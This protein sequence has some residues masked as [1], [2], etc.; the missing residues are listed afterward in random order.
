MSVTEQIKRLQKVR[1]QIRTRMVNLGLSEDTALLQNLANDLDG[2]VKR[3]SDDVTVGASAGISNITSI[4]TTQAT[5]GVAV[6]ATA[7]STAS[8]T[9][10]YYP[11]AV[12][13]TPSDSASTTIKPVLASSVTGSASVPASLPSG[14]ISITPST[15]NTRRIYKDSSTSNG[16]ITNVV[17]DEMSSA[18]L[19]TSGSASVVTTPA[20]TAGV[21]GTLTYK[22]SSTKPSGTDGTDFYTL[23]PNIASTTA[24][25]TTASAT[26]TVTAS[27]H[28]AK[29][30]TS[31]KDGLEVVVDVAKNKGTSTYLP[32]STFGDITTTNPTSSANLKSVTPGTDPKYVPVS[33][34][35]RSAGK[36][37]VNAIPSTTVTLKAD[38]WTAATTSLELGGYTQLVTATGVTTSSHV[39]VYPNDT[40]AAKT[41]GVYAYSQA[42]NSLTFRAFDKP[43]ADMKYKV[44]YFS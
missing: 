2:V 40:T 17:I 22:L 26:T 5:S 28:L 34:G 3:S 25:K 4:D 24:A 11:S 36:I 27:G 12:A 44:Y 21:E 14:T 39:I 16:F 38:S 32:A 8:V 15:D 19:S 20:A 37:T 35:Y 33:A 6:T 10:G 18:T 41:Y 42:K 31:T 9:S 7:K 43:T 13:K 29:D 30:T 1:N 23:T